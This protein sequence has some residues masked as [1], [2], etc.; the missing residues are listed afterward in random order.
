[1]KKIKLIIGLILFFGIKLSAQTW[2]MIPDANFVTYLQSII[3]AAMNGNLM[4]TSSIWVTTNTHKINIQNKGISN[5]N[6]VQYFTSLDTL[7]F[8]N[9]GAGPNNTV[10]NIPALPNTLTYLNFYANNNVSSLPALPNTLTYLNCGANNFSSLP[11]LPTSLKYF[12]CSFNNLTSLPA[13]PSTLQVLYCFHNHLQSLPLLGNALTF[14]SCGDNYV[15]ASLPVLPNSLL[16]LECGDNHLSSLPALPNQ[17][18]VLI[19][20]NN[21]LG[22]LP[23]LP[24]SLTYI[25]CDTDS[26]TSL[27]TLPNSLIT[28]GCGTNYLTSLPTLPN[29]LTNLGCESN[30]LTNLPSLPNSLTSLSCDSN[31]IDCFPVFPNSL[32]DTN[33]FNIKGNPYTC[34]PNYVMGMGAV[35]LVKPLCTAGNT[36][37]CPIAVAGIRQITSDNYFFTL[38]PNPTNGTTVNID[39]QTPINTEAQIVVYDMMSRAVYSNNLHNQNDINS[40]YSLDVSTLSSGIYMVNL[41]IDKVKV[42]QKFIKQ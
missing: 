25:D 14:L 40:T 4:D 20:N 9:S 30:L 42:Y 8:S 18:Q 15:L 35:Y 36:N 26:L 6:G 21:S 27:P 34:L 12:N 2:V 37:G 5:L 13:L 39:L 38:Y 31:N 11:T 16:E 33:Y 10:T 32:A 19:C 22:T 29:T 41:V 24:N 23:T 17:L 28:L 3:P 7:N 1:M